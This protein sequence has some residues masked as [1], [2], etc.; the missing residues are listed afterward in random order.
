MLFSRQMHSQTW[1]LGGVNI[2]FLCRNVRQIQI[3]HWLPVEQEYL[4]LCQQFC[5]P[6]C[7]SAAVSHEP[8]V[9]PSP[10]SIRPDG[11][12]FPAKMQQRRRARALPLHLPPDR[13]YLRPRRPAHLCHLNKLYKWITNVFV[14]WPH[15]AEMANTQLHLE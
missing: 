5:L 4:D 15:C 8:P 6:R 1:L 13:P 10:Q 3:H 7:A 11:N 14:G 2:C 9:P 12:S